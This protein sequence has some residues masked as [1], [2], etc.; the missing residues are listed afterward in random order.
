[1]IV[2][3][4]LWI[5]GRAGKKALKGPRAIFAK[6][7]R[8]KGLKS[9]HTERQVKSRVKMMRTII[10][11]LSRK[12]YDD[13]CALLQKYPSNVA[14]R[15]LIY[16]IDATLL[17]VCMYDPATARLSEV[18]VTLVLDVGS[19]LIVGWHVHWGAPTT[20]GTLRALLHALLPKDGVGLVGW[21]IPWVVQADNG[22]IFNGLFCELGA[23]HL[24]EEVACRDS[25]RQ[26][27]GRKM[28]R[29]G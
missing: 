25:D 21:G 8:D 3:W 23:A 22:S 26:R 5:A 4:L 24:L 10:Q 19:R 13:V 18:W 9:F 7:R 11:Q 17:P 14:V 16:Q 2:L 15:R 12:D 27:G 6:L 28:H 20:L 1:M 29:L